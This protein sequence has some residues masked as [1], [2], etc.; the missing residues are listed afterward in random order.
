MF[1][2][3]SVHSRKSKNHFTNF[4]V[5]VACGCGSVLLWQRCDTWDDVVFS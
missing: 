3:L 1:V 2:F 4:F 5:Q